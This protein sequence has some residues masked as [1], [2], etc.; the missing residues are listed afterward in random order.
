MKSGLPP[1]VPFGPLLPG[2][3]FCC[4][5]CAFLLSLGERFLV[6]GHQHLSQL[7][8]SS[9]SQYICCNS[10]FPLCS[11]GTS[12]WRTVFSSTSGD[13]SP[14]QPTLSH[15]LP[16]HRSWEDI[17]FIFLLFFGLCILWVG[18]Q[19]SLPV[20]FMLPFF[21]YGC[22]CMLG[23][24]GTDWSGRRLTPRSLE[25]S[26]ASQ[27]KWDTFRSQ[28]PKPMQQFYHLPYSHT[29]IQYQARERGAGYRDYPA[30]VPLF[31]P[32]KPPS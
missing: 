24:E 14:L 9:E 31:I 25:F 16:S 19:H 26:W 12:L 11:P 27:K 23:C 1:L 7:V 3:L 6:Q 10:S 28:I 2:R 8:S 18:S 13:H 30:C 21:F 17:L 32:F 20:H 5:A 15:L 4:R 29:V 22:C